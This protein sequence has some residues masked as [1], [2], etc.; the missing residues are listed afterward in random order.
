MYGGV[1]KQVHPV[2]AVNAGV[3]QLKQ[4]IAVA[5]EPE[6]PA[7]AS[8]LRRK[9]PLETLNVAVLNVTDALQ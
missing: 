4:F 8:Y 2:A 3:E 7:K 1:S 9:Y 6:R 5:R